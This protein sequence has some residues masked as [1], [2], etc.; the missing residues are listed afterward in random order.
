MKAVIEAFNAGKYIKIDLKG[1]ISS[2]F[3][4]EN[5]KI[6]CDS[7]ALGLFEHP[8]S[9]EDIIKHFL[10]MKNEGAIFTILE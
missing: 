9:Y 3:Y 4:I 7:E 2:I 10:D 8:R 1:Y 6:F 5:N